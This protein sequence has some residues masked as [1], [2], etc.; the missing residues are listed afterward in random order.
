MSCVTQTI[1]SHFTW[2]IV[3]MQTM[4][5]ASFL[6]LAIAWVACAMN[7]NIGVRVSFD[8]QWHKGCAL[9]EIIFF[10]LMELSL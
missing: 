2:L 7:F 3:Y 5:F 4:D 10:A 9:Q 1:H 8:F 6:S